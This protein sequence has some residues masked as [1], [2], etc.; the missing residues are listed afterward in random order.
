MKNRTFDCV[1]M[2]HEGARRLQEKLRGMSPDQQ[3][4]YWQKRSEEFRRKVQ[5]RHKEAEQK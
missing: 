2:K 1:R 5:M 3:T 4:A